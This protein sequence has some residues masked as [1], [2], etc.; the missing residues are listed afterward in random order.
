MVSR[1]SMKHHWSLRLK[2]RLGYPNFEQMSSQKDWL[3]WGDPI[4]RKLYWL[5]LY[6]HVCWLAHELKPCFFPFFVGQNSCCFPKDP[7]KTSANHWDKRWHLRMPRRPY[8]SIIIPKWR[9]WSTFAPQV[10]RKDYWPRSNMIFG[11]DLGW[12]MVGKRTRLHKHSEW[13]FRWI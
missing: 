4:M 11:G 3:F 2:S 13:G 8:D 5:K 9:P 7:R 10:P 12:E 6:P 1:S